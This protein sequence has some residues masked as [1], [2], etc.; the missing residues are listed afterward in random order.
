MLFLE[1]VVGFPL[2]F[3]KFFTFCYW[4]Q[5]LLV[6]DFGPKITIRIVDR[7]REDIL[8]GKLKSGAEIKVASIETI[9]AFCESCYQVSFLYFNR[10][11]RAPFVFGSISDSSLKLGILFYEL[12][13]MEIDSL[14]VVLP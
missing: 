6:A 5:V 1:A 9:G 10:L 3:R 7:L 2:R 14:R 8:A 4:F 12:I 13:N 11:F